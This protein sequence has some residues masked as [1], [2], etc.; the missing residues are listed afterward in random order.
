M[1]K[2]DP[3][4]FQ[5][6]PVIQKIIRDETWLEGERRRS[7]V[8]PDDPVVREKVCAIILNIG[9]GLRA[10]FQGTA[11]MEARPILISDHSEAA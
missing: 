10:M 2:L 11:T 1:T 5:E 9:A 8:S 3:I 7:Y 4:V 6:I